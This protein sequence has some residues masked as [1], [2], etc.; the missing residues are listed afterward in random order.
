MPRT[1]TIRAPRPSCGWWGP[2][3]YEEG[4]VEVDGEAL[5]EQ[6]LVDPGGVSRQG[7][8]AAAESEGSLTRVADLLHVGLAQLVEDY[9]APRGGKEGRRRWGGG[10][11]VER[12]VTQEEQE[13]GEE[14]AGLVGSTPGPAKQA[15]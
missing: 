11:R 15:T 2:G 13:E 12:G 4:R 5:G 10:W 1:R 3:A 7:G 9:T 14:Q 8:R 6:G